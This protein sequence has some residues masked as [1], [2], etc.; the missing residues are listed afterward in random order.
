M[1]LRIVTPLSE[2]ERTEDKKNKVSYIGTWITDLPINQ[3]NVMEVVNAARSRW[4]IENECFNTL[5]NY[6]YEIEHN[7]GHGEK[8]LCFNFYLLT[9]IAFYVH[10]ILE[11]CDFMFHA[12]RKYYCTLKE[13]WIHIRSAFNWFLYDSWE[14]MMDH[15]SNPEK[16]HFQLQRVGP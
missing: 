6:G 2:K 14:T 11:L 15:A 12:V 16:Y 9:L 4:R 10:Q 5:K 3:Q 7:Y 1:K 8:N 13:T